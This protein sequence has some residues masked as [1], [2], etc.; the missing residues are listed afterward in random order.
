MNSTR[1]LSQEPGVGSDKE[2]GTG[3]ENDPG[4][5]KCS[6]SGSGSGGSN[7]VGDRNSPLLGAIHKGDRDKPSKVSL[8][9]IP[10]VRG[11]V[12]EGGGKQKT[13]HGLRKVASSY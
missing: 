1:E 3:S 13:N 12:W 4:I 10:E 2:P 6:G 7:V 11:K 8:D 9:P 5:G